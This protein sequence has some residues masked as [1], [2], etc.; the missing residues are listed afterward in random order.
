MAT[1]SR[2]KFLIAWA[3]L[4]GVT[5]VWARIYWERIPHL[6]EAYRGEAI[7]GRIVDAETGAPVAGAVVIGYHE[8]VKPFGLEAPIIAG[9][10]H[11]AEA[12]TD[13]DG[14]Y[15][16]PAWGPV[17]RPDKS[18]LRRD[19]PIL[20]IYREGYRLFTNAG[21]HPGDNRSVLTSRYDGRTIPLQRL[22]DGLEEEAR[23][24]ARITTIMAG[25]FEPV[26]GAGPCDWREIPRTVSGF[27]RLRRRLEANDLAPG[28]LPAIDQLEAQGNCGN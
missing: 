4:A 7:H 11:V 24:A 5:L 1:V 15:H 12:V 19:E 17:P 26:F 23:E 2:K 6:P 28:R 18:Y 20:M 13:A 8:L 10:L 9:K 16:L 14:R 21:Y 27:D 25:V 22:E 3:V